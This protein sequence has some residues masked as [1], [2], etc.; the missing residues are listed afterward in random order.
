MC[1]AHVVGFFENMS[2]EW[3]SMATVLESMISDGARGPFRVF[4]SRICL[5]LFKNFGNALS[6]H[7]SGWI[8]RDHAY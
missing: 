6:R 5:A 1:S 3:S 4:S 7:S 2:T 8:Q